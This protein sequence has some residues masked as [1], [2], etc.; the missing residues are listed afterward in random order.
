MRV[1]S[2]LCI[3]AVLLAIPLV[4][5]E[6][7]DSYGAISGYV[8]LAGNTAVN[9][10]TVMICSYYCVYAQTDFWGHYQFPPNTYPTNTGTLSFYAWTGSPYDPGGQWGSNEDVYITEPACNYYDQFGFCQSTG[11]YI[12]FFL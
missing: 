7:T 10:A 12:D 2:L 3:A 8:Q 11:Y 6:Q 4:A 5:Q 9:G 1:K